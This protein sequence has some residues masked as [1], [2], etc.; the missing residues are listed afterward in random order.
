VSL[1]RPLITIGVP[2]YQGQNDLPITLECLRTQSYSNLDVLISVDADDQDSARACE[3][4]LLNDPRFRVHVQSR[5]LGW[6]ANTDWTMRERRGDFYIFQQHDDEVSSDY[7]AELVAAA[8]RAP[9]AAICFAEMQYTG[10][11]DAIDRGFSVRGDPIARVLTFLRRMECA[12]LR[13]L[14]RSSALASTSGLLLSDFDPFE[15]FGT[16]TRFLA[17]LALWGDFIFVPGPVYFKRIH[18]ANLHLKRKSWADE[19]NR[20]SWACLCAWMIE[21]I[22][23]AGQTSA[24]RR[25]LFDAVLKRFL[26]PSHRW[27]LF[28]APIRWLSQTRIQVLHPIRAF[29]QKLRNNESLVRSVTSGWALYEPKNLEDRANFVR[30]VFDQLKRD[31]R[32]NPAWVQSSWEVLARQTTN[33]WVG[34]KGM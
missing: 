1:N 15:S 5:R 4:F 28:R 3:P 7:I 25:E 19:R 24:E 21:V 32:F 13:G 12:P 29:F 22:V 8:S 33:G 26:S 9:N 17:E 10:L 18:G 23:S 31:A 16:E 2:V 20:R 6:A 27:E 30:L 11:V 14:I 34:R